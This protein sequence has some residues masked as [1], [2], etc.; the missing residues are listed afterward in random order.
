MTA[1]SDGIEAL[2]QALA[3][4][5]TTYRFADSTAVSGWG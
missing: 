4:A 2:A 3:V 5:A 1:S